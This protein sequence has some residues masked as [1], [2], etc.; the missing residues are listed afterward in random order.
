MLLVEFMED[1]P[2]RI[3]LTAV[4]SQLRARRK[5]TDTKQPMK[6]RSLINLLK[7]NDINVTKHD[8]FDMIKVAP[9]KNIIDNIQG[10]N[11]IFKGEH[12]EE[13]TADV[14]SDKTEKTLDKMAKRASK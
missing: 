7:D 12:G 6:V 9:L 4:V 3:R 14:D 1:D 5:D 10:E 2:L 13:N 11:V 8:L